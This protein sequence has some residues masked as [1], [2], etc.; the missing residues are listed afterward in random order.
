MPDRASCAV[1]S[2]QDDV[3]FEVFCWLAVLDPPGPR[4]QYS[5]CFHGWILA[6]HVCKRWRHMILGMPLLWARIPAAFPYSTRACTTIIQRSAA[7]PLTFWPPYDEG[8][9]IT[10]GAIVL[11]PDL[12]AIANQH[13]ERAVSIAGYG[14]W[15]NPPASEAF[16]GRS[17][18]HLKILYVFDHSEDFAWKEGLEAP[19]LDILLLYRSFFNIRAP[20]LRA[21]RVDLSLGPYIPSPPYVLEVLENCLLLEELDLASLFDVFLVDETYEPR[22][23]PIELSRLANF[24]YS[25]QWPGFSSIWLSINVPPSV[26]LLVEFPALEQ[27]VFLLFPHIQGCLRSSSKYDTLRI[28]Y[29]VNS[30]I[31][32]VYDSRTPVYATI[33]GQEVVSGVSICL[34]DYENIPAELDADP[35]VPP[36]LVIAALLRSLNP[37][38]I[39]H[40]DL[41]IAFN[42]SDFPSPTVMREVLRALDQVKTLAVGHHAR[43]EPISLFLRGSAPG[44]PAL[45]FPELRTLI[46]KGAAETIPPE[47]RFARGSAEGNIWETWEYINSFVSSLRA[48]RCKALRHIEVTEIKDMTVLGSDGVQSFIEARDR[49]IRNLEVMGVKVELL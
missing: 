32:S 11:T 30:L 13:L 1:N 35:D 4:T 40:I 12:S 48:A 17:A 21:L 33:S 5:K 22:V 29:T 36:N 26:R 42:M 10:L 7:A 3:L 27:G 44:L 8:R 20:I 34:S 18:P 41:D 31:V 47:D 9:V 24:R 25:G 28:S 45:V 38:Q 19:I 23:E 16:S 46:L 6:S 43:F 14:G 37:A 15:Y 49:C 2:L 39:H